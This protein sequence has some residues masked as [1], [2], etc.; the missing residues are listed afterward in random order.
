MIPIFCARRPP[1]SRPSTR[2]SRKPARSRCSTRSRDRTGQRS[3]SSASTERDET[4]ERGTDRHR[5]HRPRIGDAAAGECGGGDGPGP[6]QREHPRRPADEQTR[7]EDGAAVDLGE[8]G[9]DP[10][11]DRGETCEHREAGA[12][13]REIGALARES[14]DVLIVAGVPA[15]HFAAPNAATTAAIAA[16]RATPSASSRVRFDGGKGSPRRIARSFASQRR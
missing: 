8:L 6:Q 14:G 16:A 9:Q 4:E 7:D 11:R 5:A 10:L 13:P 1:D 3:G 12:R 15:V 2:A